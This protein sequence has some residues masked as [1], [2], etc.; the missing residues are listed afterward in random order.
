MNREI[1][2]SEHGDPRTPKGWNRV[3]TFQHAARMG[4]LMA[5]AAALLG[6]ELYHTEATFADGLRYIHQAEQ[7]QAGTWTRRP[8]QRD[9]PS[10]PS[11]LNRRGASAPGRHR[12]GVLAARC[13]GALFRQRRPPRD[14]DLFARP[15]ALRRA[16][17]LAGLRPRDA[18]T[19]SSATS[20]STSCPR[21]PFCSGGPSASGRRSGSCARGVSS[22]C[23][24]RSVLERWRT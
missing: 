24:W 13:P 19:R 12:P 23:R 4:L 15:R 3:T 5:V 1:A 22:G 18:S 7:I 11:P 10:A 6:W 14:P 21:A 2:P 17:R 8:D 20:W 16:D 9:R